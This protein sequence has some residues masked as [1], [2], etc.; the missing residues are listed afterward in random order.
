[1]MRRDASSS[2]IREKTIGDIAIREH[3]RGDQRRILDADAVM[4]FVALA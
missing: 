3:G 2:L 4:D 1:M